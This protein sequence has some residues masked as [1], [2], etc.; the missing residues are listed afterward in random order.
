M[1]IVTTLLTGIVKMLPDVIR[2]AGTIIRTVGEGL[3]A[4]LPVLMPAIVDTVLA[5]VDGLTEN[6][7]LLVNAAVAIIGALAQGLMLALPQ[8]ITRVPEIITAIVKALISGIGQL[9]NIGKQMVYGL[10]DGIKSMIG[11]IRDKING[12]VDG[13]VG[14]VKDLLGIHSPS[15]VFAGIGGNM[16]VGLGNGFDKAMQSVRSRMQS[17]IPTAD[18]SLVT[19]TSTRAAATSDGGLQQLM[20]SAISGMA[21]AQT[22][23]KPVVVNITVDK[24]TLASVLIDPLREAAKQRGV[25]YA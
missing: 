11:W 4:A 25:S 1:S 6:I 7:D 22:D 10:W 14:G 2:S 24:R 5:I 20:A 18:L 3:I 16:A 19:S 15:T 9:E 23:S 17:A 21:A 12:F 13:I 8:L